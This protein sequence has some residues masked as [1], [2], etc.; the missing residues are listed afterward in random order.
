MAKTDDPDHYADLPRIVTTSAPSLGKSSWSHLNETTTEPEYVED[1]IRIES[2]EV[3]LKQMRD[4]AHPADIL[5]RGVPYVASLDWDKALSMH[6]VHLYLRLP[7]SVVSPATR[8][9]VHKE[10]DALGDLFRE[11]F[12][13]QDFA[14]SVHLAS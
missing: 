2:L 5:Y 1:V 3:L 6:H 4:R 7:F 9:G 10:L 8:Q 12:K 13:T 11:V 14:L